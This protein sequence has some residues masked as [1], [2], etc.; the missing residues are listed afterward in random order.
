M[1]IKY[2][3]KS[4]YK[5]LF[6]IFVAIAFFV[7]IVLVKIFFLTI[8]DSK[9]LQSRALS[10]WMRGLPLTANRG[11]ITDRNGVVLASS[12]TTFDV[13]VRPADMENS[14]DMS[15]YLAK[16]L[17]LSQEKIYEKIH[18]KRLSEIKVATAVSKFVVQEILNNY[19]S[20][21]FFAENTT[22]NYEY[23]S[24][25]SQIIGFVS[26]DGIG[27]TGIEKYYNKYLEGIDGKSLVESDLKGTTIEG[28]TTTYI[29]AIDG[30]DITLTIDFAI[31]NI[32]EEE[33]LSAYLP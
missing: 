26:S 24:M 17:G 23:K 1:E 2:T 33:I 25:L 31:Q 6:A 21:I 12:Y 3:E 7:V 27:Q 8:V 22:R 4:L 19:K 5:R 13:Y 15:I 18:N 30:L 11:S 10:Q 20:G 14:E 28:S 32:L 16:Y 29:D 9:I